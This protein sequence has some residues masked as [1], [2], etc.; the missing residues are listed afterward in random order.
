METKV[1]TVLTSLISILG[2]VYLIFW[3]YRGYKVDS[4]RQKMF[5]LR[6]ELFDDAARG[7]I[8]FSHPSYQILRTTMNGFIRFAH[9]LDFWTLIAVGLSS[10]N[11]MSDPYD[12][13]FY[14]LTHYEICQS[15]RERN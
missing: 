3:V 6:N 12:I 15:P 2:L 7:E 11:T 10:K 1:F 9:K 14:T 5:Y 13:D 8:D 4:F